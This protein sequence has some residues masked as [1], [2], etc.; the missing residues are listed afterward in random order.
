MVI[1]KYLLC[2]FRIIKVN[3]KLAFLRGIDFD[4]ED[5]YGS[6]LIEYTVVKL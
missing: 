4:G 5:R 2:V 1:F 6:C 3:K